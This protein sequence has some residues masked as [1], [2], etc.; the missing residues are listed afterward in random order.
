MVCP[1]CGAEVPSDDAFCGKCGYAMREGAPERIDQSRIRVHEEADPVGPP[2]TG[3][4]E[5]R[6]RKATMVG[7][8]AL[9]PNQAPE[10]TPA[11]DAPPP[12]DISSAKQRAG[13]RT[14][15]KTMLGIPRPDFQPPAES[16][17]PAGPPPPPADAVRPSSAAPAPSEDEV[18][19]ES[20]RPPRARARVRYDS[21][22]ESFPM[23]Q[24]RK[25]AL[26][27]LA[28]LVVLAGAWFVY[29]FLTLNG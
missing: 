2:K 6:I 4:S 12:T 8:P 27:G 9:T 10:P 17:P 26:R 14:P 28:V 20:A 15:Q 11:P 23:L 3:S 5:Q 19:E 13:K 25:R 22:N 24:R 1:Q 7:M 29:R 18:V 16:P 21:A